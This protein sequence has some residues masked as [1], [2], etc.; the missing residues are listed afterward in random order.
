MKLC[1]ICSSN[2]VAF[3]YSRMVT[4]LFQKRASLFKQ[5]FNPD[6]RKIETD[7][8]YISLHH[9]VLQIFCYF[10][11]QKIFHLFLLFTQGTGYQILIGLFCKLVLGASMTITDC[12]AYHSQ[13]QETPQAVR[14][15][16]NSH[17]TLDWNDRYLQKE[18]KK[19][20]SSA[21]F[22]QQQK[23]ATYSGHSHNSSGV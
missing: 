17:A 15:C 11:Q 7:S 10:K 16:Q 12:F 2:C 9:C 3:K 6:W 18:L 13:N 5:N 20:I 1:Q 22:S 21:L 14:S 19:T 8:C 23:N 4:T